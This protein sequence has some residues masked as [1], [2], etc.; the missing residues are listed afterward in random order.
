MT[1]GQCHGVCLQHK[2]SRISSR[3]Y[4]YGHE[5]VARCKECRV[6]ILWQFNTLCPCCNGH[7]RYN[8]HVGIGK[9]NKVVKRY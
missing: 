1:T 5:G 3:S 4:Y 6:F 9:K 8:A 7:L 2:V